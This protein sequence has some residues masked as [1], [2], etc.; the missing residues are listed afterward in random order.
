MNDPTVNSLENM[1]DEG[2]L[3][4]LWTVNEMKASIIYILEHN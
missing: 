4:N 2:K 1:R 3:Q